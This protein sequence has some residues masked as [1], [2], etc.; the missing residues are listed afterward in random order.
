MWEEEWAK[1]AKQL[2]QWEVLNKFAQTVL[3]P[4]LQLECSWR[5]SDWQRL[6]HILESGVGLNVHTVDPNRKLYQLYL[7]I[8]DR[9]TQDR[10]ID[11]LCDRSIQ[12]ALREWQA[13][14]DFVNNRWVVTTLSLLSIIALFI[15][16]IFFLRQQQGGCNHARFCP[17]HSL[18]SL[19]ITRSLTFRFLHQQ[20]SH[21][22]L[23]QRFHRIVELQESAQMLVD[24]T[25]YARQGQLPPLRNFITT[26]RERLANKWEEIPVWSDI[27]TWRNHMFSLV[28]ASF[29]NTQDPTN[30][31][32][33]SRIVGSIVSLL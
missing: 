15:H 13:L 31:Q 12:L 9:K 4:Q 1:C 30:P 5:L 17:N 33:T 29:P 27:L 16:C 10:E 7:A 25:T 8:N 14:P 23:L 3:H 20:N 21:L 19:S 28:T 6:K 22:D 32:Y 11:R 26:W 24:I 18:P 2:N